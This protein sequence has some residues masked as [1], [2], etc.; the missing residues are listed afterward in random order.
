MTQ[1]PLTKYS[2]QMRT[3]RIAGKLDAELKDLPVPEPE[4]NEVRIKVAFVGVCGSDLHYYFEGANG[5]FIVQ[6]PLIPGHELS[7]TID[8]DPSGEFAAGTAVTVHPATFGKS[9][10]EIETDPHIWPGGKYLGSASTMPHTQG[11][12]S[13]Y[14][15]ARKDM[16]RILPMGLSLKDAALAE[17]LAVALH[18][19]NIAEGVVEKKVLVSGSGPIGLLVAAAARIKGAQEVV[20]TD[21]LTGPLE[22]ARAIGAT[23]TIQISK[24]ELPDNYFD[25]VFEC[26]GSPIA[27]SS[28]LSAVRRAG[29]VIQVGM[30]GAGPQPIAIASLVSK[31]IRLKGAFRFNNEIVEAIELLSKHS[32]ITSVITHV[33]PASD[34]KKA[35]EIAK[36]SQISGKVLVDFQ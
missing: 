12:M 30:L 15:I 16:V 5:A 32:V 3:F 28:A 7:G 11:A 23:K 36:D 6:E 33:M 17:P 1:M 31:E 29:T 13:D 18:A 25:C 21:V 34:V 9:S 27:L 24:E 4:L 8:I 14:F 19:I 10:P 2:A 26:S 22:R 20:C 35:F